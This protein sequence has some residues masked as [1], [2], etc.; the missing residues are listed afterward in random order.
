MF[1]A[2]E[3]RQMQSLICLPFM[4][5]L[6]SLE[7]MSG[8]IR[9]NLSAR[10]LEMILNL[11]FAIA[12]GLNCPIVSALGVLGIR[13]TVFELKLGINQLVLKNSK[14]ALQTSSLMISQ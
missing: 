7:I 3:V 1:I 13:T 11:K 12:I 10:I 6:S 14:R 8:R 9:A 4:N 2:S 5:P